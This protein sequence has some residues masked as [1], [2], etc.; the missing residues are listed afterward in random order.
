[1]NK[2]KKFDYIIAGAGAAGMTL[3]WFMLHSS[4]RKK[5][6][7]LI[8]R[9]LEP[10]NDKTWCFWADENI[11]YNDLI[12]HTWNNLEIKARG[13]TYIE[14]LS[15][16]SYHCVRSYDHFSH[17][18]E[19][20]E[21]SD[22]VTLLEADIKSFTNTGKR[23][24]VDTTKGIFEADWIFQSAIKP[25]ALKNAKSDIRLMQHFLGWEI[26]TETPLFDA[27]K[28]TLMDFDVPQKNGVT[29]LYE[30]PFQPNKALIEYTLFSEELLSDEEYKEG[31][32]QYLSDKYSLKPDDY[33]ILRREKGV[34]PMEDTRHPGWYSKRVM[35]IG[36]VGGLTK[37]TTGYTFTRIHHHSKL[38]V[39]SLE[40]GK[41]PPILN[42]SDYRF[43]VYDIMLL[44]LLQNHHETS[45]DIFNQLFQKNRFDRI[46]QFLEEKT[47]IGQELAIFSTL[48]YLPFFKSIWKMKHRIF[49]GA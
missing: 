33:N 5:K 21:N 34:I 26:E 45:I 24:K 46:L 27:D 17:I 47:H 36:T 10:K 39:S 16:Y 1:M 20:A 23:G 40:Q 18:K 15:K 35:N 37:P 12:Y 32:E 2:I 4:L 25:P 28:V 13:N 22:T 31:I 8:D 48:P 49:S 19:L 7:L 11:P 30:L 6:I 9:S 41:T 3:L 38:I 29:F 14:E 44:Y 43:R 42:E